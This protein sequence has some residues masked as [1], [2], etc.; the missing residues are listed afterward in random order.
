M[1]EREG[2]RED[3]ERDNRFVRLQAAPLVIAADTAAA[4][5][6]FDDRTMS[7]PDFL[8]ARPLSASEARL[9]TP[10]RP[11]YEILAGSRRQLDSS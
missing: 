9:E 5:D 4:S 11:L 10:L 6:S 7:F 8:V 2:G 3:G 1:K